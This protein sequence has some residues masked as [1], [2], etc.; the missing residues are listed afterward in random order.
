M[1]K[2]IIEQPTV[3]DLDEWEGEVDGYTF[4]YQ[5]K[6]TSGGGKPTWYPIRCWRKGHP[7]LN[8]GG[9]F[10]DLPSREQVEAHFAPSVRNYIKIHIEKS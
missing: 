10:D 9:A 5:I 7:L 1:P 4:V 2:R 6:Q 3:R 8:M